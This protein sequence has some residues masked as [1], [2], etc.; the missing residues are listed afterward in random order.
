[1]RSSYRL[2]RRLLLG[3]NVD[4][5]KGRFD[6]PEGRA[7]IQLAHERFNK[8]VFHELGT[9]QRLRQRLTPQ[10]K[11]HIH[12]H[13]KPSVKGFQ[14]YHKFSADDCVVHELCWVL[15]GPFSDVESSNTEASD[16]PTQSSSSVAVKSSSQ[17]DIEPI[18]VPVLMVKPDDLVL[19]T[20]LRWRDRFNSS[21]EN[22]TSTS[23]ALDEM[24]LYTYEENNSGIPSLVM[25]GLDKIFP[26]SVL[27]SPSSSFTAVSHLSSIPNP[28]L[29]A[30]MEEQRTYQLHRS[31]ILSA[32]EE[33]LESVIEAVQEE[34]TRKEQAYRQAHPEAAFRTSNASPDASASPMLYTSD[35]VSSYHDEGSSVPSPQSAQPVDTSLLMERFFE[36][37]KAEREGGYKSISTESLWCEPIQLRVELHDDDDLVEPE[38]VDPLNHYNGSVQQPKI[39]SNSHNLLYK[40]LHSPLVAMPVPVDNVSFSLYVAGGLIRNEE[41]MKRFPFC[42]ARF[43]VSDTTQLATEEA[44]EAISAKDTR[45]VSRSTEPLSSLCVPFPHPSSP[46]AELEVYYSPELFQLSRTIGME[47]LYSLRCFIGKVMQLQHS[48]TA[49]S[50]SILLNPI[51]LKVE[52]ETKR[53][54]NQLEGSEAGTIA[55]NVGVLAADQCSLSIPWCPLASGSEGTLSNE[56]DDSRSILLRKKEAVRCVWSIWGHLVKG[57]HVSGDSDNMYLRIH[58]QRDKQETAAYIKGVQDWTRNEVVKGPYEKEVAA[59]ESQSNPQSEPVLWGPAASL[60]SSIPISTDFTVIECVLEKRGLPHHDVFEDLTES[61]QHMQGDG[62]SMIRLATLDEYALQQQRTVNTERAPTGSRADDLVPT[63]VPLVYTPKLVVSHSGVVMKGESHTFQR[64]RIRG[65]QVAHVQALA[66][67]LEKGTHFSTTDK[68]LVLPPNLSIHSERFCKDERLQLREVQKNRSV[69]TESTSQGVALELKRD[70]VEV[71]EDENDAAFTHQESAEEVAFWKS[72]YYKLH[73][74]KLIFYDKVDGAEILQSASRSPTADL[75]RK[76][77]PLLSSNEIGGATRRS[78]VHRTGSKSHRR[79]VKKIQVSVPVSIEK[80]FLQRC[81]EVEWEAS[82]LDLRR[83]DSYGYQYELRLR[84]IRKEDTPL[85]I[86]ALESVKHKGFINYFPPHRFSTFTEMNRH[87]GLSLLKGEFYQAASI[88]A[89]QAFIDDSLKME[90]SRRQLPFS[91]LLGMSGKGKRLRGILD[92]P[93]HLTISGH[94][95]TEAVLERA[96][97]IVQILHNAVQTTKL[98]QNDCSSAVSM[99]KREDEAIEAGSVLWPSPVGIVGQMGDE[100]GYHA[101][102]DP[103]KEAFLQVLGAHVCRSLIHEFLAFVWNDIVNQRLQRYGT[104]AVLPGDLVRLSPPCSM[105]LPATDLLDITTRDVL[106]THRS[107]TSSLNA[108]SSSHVLAFATQQAIDKK[109]LHWWDVVVPVP[110]ADVILPQNHTADLYVLTLKR[111]NIPFHPESRQWEIFWPGVGDGIALSDEQKVCVPLE[112]HKGG[113]AVGLRIPAQYRSPLVCPLQAAYCFDASLSPGTIGDPYQRWGDRV[114][115]VRG[116][117]FTDLPLLTTEKKPLLNATRSLKNPN[118]LSG[119]KSC[120]QRIAQYLPASRKLSGRSRTLSLPSYPYW[121]PQHNDGCLDLRIRLPT[122]VSPWMMIRELVKSDVSQSDVV[123]LREHFDKER[124]N[125]GGMGVHG[126]KGTVDY[127]LA[128]ADPSDAAQRWRKSQKKRVFEARPVAMS[129]ALLHQHIF[130]SSGVRQSL[131][132]TLRSYDS[133]SK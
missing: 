59:A 3:L 67:A 71:A 68:G 101:E 104:F 131:I 106:D 44:P 108:R 8:G 25:D 14:A 52:E 51:Q 29:K 73:N 13:A 116:S 2:Y 128:V 56:K 22:E 87:P 9:A 111:W 72:H 97:S 94:R 62:L 125:L 28:G 99:G 114:V 78:R 121:Y 79:S 74:I 84:K 21:E 33:A 47:G 133:V 112:K 80:T 11:L 57:L 126:K 96:N 63:P 113:N 86:K 81:S 39:T 91:P 32:L 93:D 49:L 46:A 19:R 41:F 37:T 58:M 30:F 4:E 75:P 95:H 55:S 123:R 1:M 10:Q 129:L 98:L 12:R 23:A 43:F 26:E 16:T 7:T 27:S 36:E 6:T 35:L 24:S 60:S 65:S 17:K 54:S 34:L 50:P 118:F 77:T 110:G 120:R 45:E 69:Q 119:S 130:R 38:E 66:D 117:S 70:T 124:E 42:L 76:S 89:E 48:P 40:A 88:V 5:T 109:L 20:P 85:A 83:E 102:E 115:Q 61:L 15:R 82:Q 92:T 103:C 53:L 122:G 18:L 100:N 90:Q 132:P 64:I 105:W 31:L 127:K 107:S